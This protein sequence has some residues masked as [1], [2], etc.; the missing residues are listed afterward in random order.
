MDDEATQQLRWAEYQLARYRLELRQLPDG[1][2]RRRASE[3]LADY[4]D[5]EVRRLTQR[6]ALQRKERAWATN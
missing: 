5:V 6:V 2:G 4:W 3:I 1:D